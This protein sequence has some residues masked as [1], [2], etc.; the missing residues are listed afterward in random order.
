VS[1]GATQRKALIAAASPEAARFLRGLELTGARPKELA[2]TVVADFTGP[3]IETGSSE[4]Q[5]SQ[6]PPATCGAGPPRKSRSSMS[7]AK[8]S[9]EVLLC[10]TEDGETPWRRHIWARETRAAI[11]KHNEQAK[12]NKRIS[13][14][15]SEYSFRHARIVS[16]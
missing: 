15:A 10:F 6:A 5:T 7:N 16:A 2:A 3:D 11:A 1:L 8:T 14:D 12:G 9:C 4:G 13:T